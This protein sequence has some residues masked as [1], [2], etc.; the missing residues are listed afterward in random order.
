MENNYMNYQK[1]QLSIELGLFDIGSGTT[2]L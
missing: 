1:K 2:I